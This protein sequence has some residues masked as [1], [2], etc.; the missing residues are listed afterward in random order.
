[1]DG[2]TI[3]RLKGGDPFIF[4]RGADE[5]AYLRGYHIPVEVIPG[6]SSATGIP[7]G[8]GIPLTARG[9]SSSVAFVSGHS[10]EE[11]HL[12]V[13][14]IDIPNVDTIVFLMGLTKLNMIIQSLRESHWPDDTPTMIISR[15]TR[16]DEKI[17]V[18]TIENIQKKVKDHDL[19]PPALIVV[20]ST[21]KFWQGKGSYGEKILYTGTN[22]DKY[23]SLGSIVHHPMIEIK[24]AALT[25]E[26]R[27]SLLDNLYGYHMILLTSRCAVKYFFAILKESNVVTGIL[28]NKDF[29]AIGQDTAQALQ[30][31]DFDSVL[32]PP[33][34]TSEG[35][36]KVL[37]ERYDLK[38]KKI[39]FPRSS[40][41]NPY[42]KEELM[43]FGSQVDELTVYE[44]SKPSLR[45]LPPDGIRKI[46]FSSPST[47]KNFLEDYGTIPKGWEIFSK[48]PVTQKYLENNG[49]ESEILIYESI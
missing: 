25:P 11:S 33:V 34:A 44:N 37:K 15:G 5:L 9:I 28:K 42:L 30:E 43:K 29:V 26:Q 35:L 18:G 27:R 14:P 46:L 47:V 41:P 48:G 10:E 8:L 6:I 4:G 38:G 13:Q 3:V 39:L 22:P 31:H 23:Q 32:I 36:L 40:L 17:V 19:H 45:P 24:Q 7:S 2:K 20:G 1:M 12:P 16:I 21:I 49:Y